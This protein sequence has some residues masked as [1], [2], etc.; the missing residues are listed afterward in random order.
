MKKH[1]KNNLKDVITL[2]KY[3][4]CAMVLIAFCELY[5]VARDKIEYIHVENVRSIT[6]EELEELSRLQDIADEELYSIDNIIGGLSKNVESSIYIKKERKPFNLTDV[7][8]F[9]APF[10]CGDSDRKCRDK[11]GKFKPYQDT[12]TFAIGYGNTSFVKNHGNNLNVRINHAQ[13]WGLLKIDTNT[14]KH[15]ILVLTSIVQKHNLYGCELEAL[16]SFVYNKGI[17]RFA[18]LKGRKA[19]QVFVELSKNTIDFKALQRS[20]ESEPHL[21]R[22]K[23]EFKHFKACY[24]ANH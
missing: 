8:N 10:E 1:I 16:T 15:Q 20:W 7:M 18:G 23:A 22:R 3:L 12:N 9:I 6:V 13:A 2:T 21:K 14:A 17:G 11:N 5:S 4:V 24:D 19:S